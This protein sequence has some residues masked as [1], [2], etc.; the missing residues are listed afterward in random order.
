MPEVG[1]QEV[2][3][4]RT[5]ARLG[6]KVRVVTSTAVSSSA[7]RIRRFPYPAGREV[8]V[9]GYEIIRLPVRFRF[10]SAVFSAHVAD[11]VAEWGPD[12]VF[13][14]GI[15]KMFGGPVLR[16]TEVQ[17]VPIVCFFSELAEYR[18][19]HS[20]PARIVSWMQ[21]RG[22]ELLKRPLYQLAF[23]R[24]QLLVCNSPGTLEWLKHCCQEQG[25]YEILKA[26]A[27]VLSLGYDS[28]LFLFR[29]EERLAVRQQLSCQGEVVVLTVTRVVPHKGLERII[30]AIG[31]L[32]RRGFPVR[33]ILIGTLG[34][35][36]EGQ[37]R[38]RAQQQP[39]PERFLLLP[40]QPSD[41]VRQFAAGADVGIWMQIAISANEAMGTGLPLLLPRR[42]S[43][44]H[45]LEEGVNGWYWEE[46]YEFENALEKVVNFLSVMPEEQ[47]IQWRNHIAAYNARRFSY[48][49]I[50]REILTAIG[51]PPTWE[52]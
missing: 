35:A 24:A 41:V 33:Y 49:A 17:H 19:R 21:D 36:Y 1:Y 6:I 18:Q 37:L 52:G 13:L 25:D 27:R 28:H 32:Q 44:R 16:A 34:D 8:A 40:F 7:R 46:P 23:R 50:L 48:E 4:A 10:R 22:F 30:D 38:R 14:I 9:E 51:M 45:L 39:C 5:L 20:L 12:A 3:I 26:K 43:L 47:R 31:Y 11:A 29:P 2:W 15:G 42:L